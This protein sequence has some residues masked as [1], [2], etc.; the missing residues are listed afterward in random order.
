MNYAS[1]NADQFAASWI[2]NLDS[3]DLDRIVALYSDV[4]VSSPLVLP[5]AS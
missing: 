5:C 1:T 2:E 3:H 4:V